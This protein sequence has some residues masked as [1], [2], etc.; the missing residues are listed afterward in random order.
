MGL[1]YSQTMRLRA[2]PVARASARA[3]RA[4]MLIPLREP[5]DSQVT[6]QRMRFDPDS[7]Q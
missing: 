4:A 3:E 1:F 6:K 2:Y 7:C 5:N